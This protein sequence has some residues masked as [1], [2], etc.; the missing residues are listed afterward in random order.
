MRV[1]NLIRDIA[2]S[3]FGG[4]QQILSIHAEGSLAT[5]R[6]TILREYDL[7]PCVELAKKAAHIDD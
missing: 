1:M 5:Q 2:V 4:Y 3:G 7:G 6:I